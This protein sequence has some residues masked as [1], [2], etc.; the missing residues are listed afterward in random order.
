MPAVLIPS[1]DV[2]ADKFFDDFPARDDVL[3]ITDSTERPGALHVKTHT[4]KYEGGFFLREEGDMVAGKKEGSWTTFY[5]DGAV[6]SQGAYQGG[7]EEGPWVRHSYGHWI[8]NLDQPSDDA[9]DKYKKESASETLSRV[10]S[11]VFSSR[12]DDAKKRRPYDLVKWDSP[13]EKV[14]FDVDYKDGKKQG[15]FTGCWGAGER[16][17]G[18]FEQGAL[19]G[20]LE[21]FHANGQ[22]ACKISDSA[23]Y[24]DRVEKVK[25]RADGTLE[26]EGLYVPGKSRE[27]NY[28]EEGKKT[29]V[30]CVSTD[31]GYKA[32][33]FHLNEDGSIKSVGNSKYADPF[34]D[35]TNL[36]HTLMNFADNI[37]AVFG[38][39][40]DRTPEQR[41]TDQMN[42]ILKSN[43]QLQV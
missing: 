27:T 16:V 32:I 28:D 43:S 41:A 24:A 5:E 19:T 4:K 42:K 18:T 26:E 33:N 23:P 31:K 9:W 11:T 2:L 13:R 14:T 37:K 12:E 34:P 36:R 6:V 15:P 1:E 3:E 10:M 20:P 38:Y 29:R 7:L 40:A 39:K 30:R 25:R 22:S 21:T 8:Y 35:Y 17:K